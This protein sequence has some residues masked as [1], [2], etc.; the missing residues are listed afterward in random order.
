MTTV[1]LGMD[2]GTADIF[3][4]SLKQYSDGKLEILTQNVPI[5][6]NAQRALELIKPKPDIFLISVGH[7]RF[8][9]DDKKKELLKGLASLKMNGQTSRVR[10]AVQI[11]SSPDDPFL[12]K[13]ALLQISDIFSGTTQNPQAVNMADVAKQLSAPSNLKNVYRYLSLNQ[14]V[15]N[16]DILDDAANTLTTQYGDD[17]RTKQL[18]KLVKVLKQQNDDLQKKVGQDTVP[19]QD[20][21]EVIE[22]LNNI[23]SSGLTNEKFSTLWKKLI[24]IVE[25]QKADIERINSINEKLNNSVVDLN[26][27]LSTVDTSSHDREINRLREENM[28]LKRSMKKV[29]VQQ[30]SPQRP[31][32]IKENRDVPRKKKIAIVNQNSGLRKFFI[33]FAAFLVLGGVGLGVI[34][35][36]AQNNQAQVSQNNT[37]PSFSELIKS[38]DYEKAVANYPR[39]AVQAENAMMS[40]KELTAKGTMAEKISKYSDNDVIKFDVDYFKG[41]YQEA[42]DIYRKSS[43]KDLTSLSE[44]RRIMVAYSL[45]KTGNISDAKQI[46]KPLNNENLNKRISIYAK[47][48]NAN[49]IL[50]NKINNGHLSRSQ[51]EKAKKQI[52]ENQKVMDKL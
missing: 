12:R 2:D 32:Y 39:K 49:K 40:D 37:K 36:V 1:L 25:K 22:E 23:M 8:D 3:R 13:L 17:G 26:N 43:E 38:G 11:D 34:R 44:E 31:V 5:F 42:V 29:S 9:D 21:D 6:H 7:I 4:N 35:A 33:G 52:R 16:L 18:E 51:I 19:R 15:D 27:Q 41:D 48:Y 46:A 14:N 24:K 28:K 20:Y 50:T 30:A 45:M 10:I 47:F